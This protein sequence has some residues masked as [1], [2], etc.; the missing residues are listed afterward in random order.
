[1]VAELEALVVAVEVAVVT[2]LDRVV[3]A[4]LVCVE[5]AEDDAEFAGIA[6]PPI[7]RLKQFAAHRKRCTQGHSDEHET[8]LLRQHI[9]STR[10]QAFVIMIL[11]LQATHSALGFTYEMRTA[12]WRSFSRFCSLNG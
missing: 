7:E 6:N 9:D 10:G 8:D 11:T 1:M 5:V 4:L 3:V 12:M 2:V